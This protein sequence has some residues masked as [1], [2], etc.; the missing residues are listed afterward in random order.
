MFDLSKFSVPKG[1]RG[2]SVIV[3]QLWWFV[4]FFFFRM[5][6]QIFYKWRV[7]ILRIFGAKIGKNVIIRPSAKITYPWKLTIG[8]NSWVGDDVVLYSLGEIIIGNNTIISQRCYICTGSHD[9]NT[10]DFKIIKSPIVVGSSSWLA[11]DVFVA[12]GV[13]IGDNCIIGARS[14]VFNDIPSNSVCLGSPAI[15][16]RDKI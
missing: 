15:K 1:F 4:D 3:V 13:K 14:S 2:R 8:D 9:Y 6:P 11:T 16:V 7:L 5:S 12:P 10:L